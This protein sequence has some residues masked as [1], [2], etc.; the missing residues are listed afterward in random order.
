[1]APAKLPPHSR[2][3]SKLIFLHC[4]SVEVLLLLLGFVCGNTKELEA[5]R[6]RRRQ[7]FL[8]CLKK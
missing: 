4:I 1:M 7:R 5:G 8:F 2:K 3:G 6:K